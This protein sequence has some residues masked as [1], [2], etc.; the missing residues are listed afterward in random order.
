MVFINSDN[1][2]IFKT[3]NLYKNNMVPVVG[4]AVEKAVEKRPVIE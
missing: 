1:K 3:G 2:I 4:P